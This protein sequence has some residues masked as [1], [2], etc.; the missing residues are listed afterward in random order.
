MVVTEDKPG[1]AKRIGKIDF[2][3]RPS[4]EPLEPRLQPEARAEALLA[5]LMAEWRREH[6]EVN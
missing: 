2:V 5:W 6:P 4:T 1:I 3:I